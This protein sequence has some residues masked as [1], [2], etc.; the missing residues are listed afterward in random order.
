[1]VDDV[2]RA[3]A[4]VRAA[5]RRLVPA[6]DR[7]PALVLAT[8]TQAAAL[9]RLEPR[10]SIVLEPLDADGVRAIAGIYAPPDEGRAIPVEA[11]MASSQGVARRV[12]EAASEWARREA[13]RRVDAVADRAAAGRN[14][15][16]TLE[17]E[18]D[19]SVV[20][21]QSARERAS[22]VA[23]SGDDDSVPIVCPYKASRRSTPT[24]PS[25]SSS[26]NGSSPSWSHA[27]S[28]RRCSRSSARPAAA[29]RRS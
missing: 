16:R 21:L 28:A 15:A 8:G 2:D 25:T 24:T 14:E 13:T 12:H 4:E 27:S 23:G 1:M 20:A 22:L 6:L 19:G 26:A 3:P 29:S 17:A 5:L 10:D 11:L 18:L 7:V 9:A